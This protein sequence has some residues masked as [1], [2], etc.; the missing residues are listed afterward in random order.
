MAMY[1]GTYYPPC[2]QSDSLKCTYHN[3]KELLSTP[4]VDYYLGCGILRMEV[5]SV[6]ELTVGN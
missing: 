4:D 6:N 5:L 1:N 2:A 3:F